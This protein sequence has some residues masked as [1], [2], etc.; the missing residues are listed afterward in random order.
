L[1]VPEKLAIFQQTT[2][3]N[4]IVAQEYLKKGRGN[5]EKALQE[6]TQ[7]AELR[8]S[9]PQPAA[10]TNRPNDPNA[11]LIARLTQLQNE[12]AQ[13]EALIVRS[14]QQ[15]A[16]TSQKVVEAIGN[17]A[18]ANDTTDKRRQQMLEAV[19]LAPNQTKARDNVH[20]LCQDHST[21]Y[22]TVMLK[23]YK[24]RDGHSD[25]IVKTTTK[26]LKHRQ[27]LLEKVQDLNS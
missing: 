6:W 14:Y 4:E 2:G 25:K 10:V 21:R 8:R 13:L 1:S 27:R 16:E 24:M 26:L 7:N 17:Y 19:A 5:L 15:A 11:E 23:L 3:Q 12:N 22:S 20:E 18:T 9:R